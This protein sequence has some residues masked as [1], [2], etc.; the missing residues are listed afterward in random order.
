[1]YIWLWLHVPVQCT[2][3]SDYTYLY[4]VHLTLTTR[5]CKMYIWL[6]L[7][8]PV[9]CT[10]DS[11]YT[12]LYNVHLTRTTRTCTMYIYHYSSLITLQSFH[13]H[14]FWALL[15][16]TFHPTL[17]LKGRTAR[18]VIFLPK[19]GFRQPWCT[20]I[21]SNMFAHYDAS[22]REPSIIGNGHS[23]IPGLTN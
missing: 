22:S 15:L 7:H 8:V 16:L 2:S 5:T 3:D 18:F 6:G 20:I 12:Y 10:S 11:D 23:K 19:L 13:L 4:N 21:C 1:M 14:K 9:Q 17:G